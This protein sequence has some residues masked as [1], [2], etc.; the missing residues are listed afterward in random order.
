[1]SSEIFAKRLKQLRKKSGWSQQKL[2]ERAGLSYNVITKI[3]QGAAKNPN[4]RTI[5]K[6]ADAFGVSLDELLNRR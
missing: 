1:M 6:L 4:I 2:A 3:E 5:I